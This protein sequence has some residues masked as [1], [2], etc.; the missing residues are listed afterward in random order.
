MKKLYKNK[1]KWI[2]GI[3][4]FYVILA[5]YY[6]FYF[7]KNMELL[8]QKVEEKTNVQRVLE[9][10]VMAVE[11]SKSELSEGDQEDV[12]NPEDQ[13]PNVD[14]T[15]QMIKTLESLE[16]LTG[17]SISSISFNDGKFELNDSTDEEINYLDLLL[18]QD[19]ELEQEEQ[20]EI[21]DVIPELHEIDI[22]LQLSG[23]YFQFIEFLEKIQNDDRF[24]LVRSIEYQLNGEKVITEQN[25]LNLETTSVDE[26]LGQLDA[27]IV[28][29]LNS[30]QGDN[31]ES[32]IAP[33]QRDTNFFVN[34]SAYYLPKQDEV[35]SS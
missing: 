29:T 18:K 12:K 8:D 13:L 5:T 33:N 20:L 34:L 3:T 14:R 11:S 17:V 22:S 32:F 31:Y 6:F 2:I 27:D 28:S 23:T 21:Q 30:V 26:L 16:A 1:T 7:Q 4:V 9:Q 19:N 10:T 35:S 25:D 24:Y 15:D